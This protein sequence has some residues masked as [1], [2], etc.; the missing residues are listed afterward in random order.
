MNEAL[1]VELGRSALVT[2]ITLA[3]P[4]LGI[5]LL[6]GLI[7]AVLQAATQINEMTLTFV[8]KL[9]AMVVVLALFGPWMLNNLV[10]YTAGLLNQLA[11]MVR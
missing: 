10:T 3:G 9:V 8:P 5:G 1:V 2:T 11:T 7:V 6:V 4:L